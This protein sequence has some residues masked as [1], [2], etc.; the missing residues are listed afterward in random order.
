MK[1]RGYTVVLSAIALML[2]A[3]Q[4]LADKNESPPSTDPIEVTANC[5]LTGYKSGEQVLQPPVAIPD[6]I[7]AGVTVGP[8][9]IPADG[10]LINDVILEFQGAHT[11]V[12]DLVIT[13]GY[14]ENC[15]GQVD[16]STRVLCRPRGT[17]ATGNAP[18]GP[19]AGVGCSSNLVVANT[20]R[21]TDG[22]ATVMAE[23]TCAGSTVNIA[24][25]CYHPSIAG[26]GTFTVFS[27]RPKGGC[28]YMNVADFAGADIGTINRWVVY[29]LN[30]PT[31]NSA[32]SWG[33]VKTL[34]R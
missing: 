31:A 21:F 16:V 33:Q 14:D 7:P 32:S 8:I 23:G 29:L 19:G 12:G 6:N 28:W 22:V 18:C 25:G 3:A 24:S 30:S 1:F 26:G 9:V 27:G 34:Y 10:S 4:A 20:Y 15:D 11:W 13:L 17:D 5:D 2:P